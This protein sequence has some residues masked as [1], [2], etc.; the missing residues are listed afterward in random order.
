MM[1]FGSVTVAAVIGVLLLFLYGK[2]VADYAPIYV[3]LMAAGIVSA[4]KGWQTVDSIGRQE[5]DVFKIH[6]K[7]FNKV[8][9]RLG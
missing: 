1:S 2:P 3:L 6:R 8:Q 5:V 4:V 9:E 7:K